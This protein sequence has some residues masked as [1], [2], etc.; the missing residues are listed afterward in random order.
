ML[1]PPTA[2]LTCERRG[3]TALA[4]VVEAWRDLAA[5]A[6][7][8]NVFYEPA[9]ALAAAPALG[10][11]VEVV[12]VWAPSGQLVGLFPIER[13]RTRWGVPIEVVVGWTHAYA[14]L[15][16]P[17]VD[18][19][20]LDAAFDAFLDHFGAAGSLPPLLLMPLVTAD[21]VVAQAL[22]GA[23][24]RRDGRSRTFGAHRRA[25]LMTGSGADAYLD[26][27]LGRKKRREIARQRRRL[28][29]DCGIECEIATAPAR[30][31]AILDEFL[32]IEAAGWKGRAGTAARQNPE[33]HAFMTK[34]VTDLA[35]EGKTIAAALRQG[36]RAI[37]ANVVLK[38]G[39]GSWGWKI[40]YDE[41]TA[42]SSP[43][44]Q[45]LID[46][47]TRLIDDPDIAWCDSCAVPDHSMIDH[48]WRE[49][50]AVEDWLI[51]LAGDLPT[52]NWATRLEAVRRRLIAVGRMTRSG[53]RKLTA[54]AH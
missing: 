52:F 46:V 24:R 19:H 23:V 22:A 27:S 9:F 45:I 20:F 30:V 32:A 44:V 15:G 34:A 50:L 16:T 53:L 47:T 26:A 35:N 8:P 14:P 7:E 36:D 3:L 5:R 2:T 28:G 38:S 41:T 33:I 54:P 37:A 12:L 10:R 1:A 4:D 18:R 6:A 17:L 11:G 48:V 39:A 42:R 31:A 21:G 13:T 49:R 40:A 43:G 29:D 51:G 25:L